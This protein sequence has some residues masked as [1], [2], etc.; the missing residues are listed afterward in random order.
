M[1]APRLTAA[2]VKRS[3]FIQPRQDDSS[4]VRPAD[5]RRFA[6]LHT[7][8]AVGIAAFG[9][10]FAQRVGLRR[11][12]LEHVI[13]AHDPVARLEVAGRG[14]VLAEAAVLVLSLVEDL[15]D[16]RRADGFAAEAEDRD[17]GAAG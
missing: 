16:R 6:R 10:E 4:I 12:L 8:A 17:D 13:A 14:V 11:L 9:D 3:F 2:T 15:G 1:G 5:L 7:V